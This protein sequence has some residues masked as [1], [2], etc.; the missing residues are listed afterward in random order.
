MA[1]GLEVSNV[2]F[3]QPVIAFVHASRY[4]RVEDTALARP[5]MMK[6]QEGSSRSDRQHL[7]EF[8]RGGYRRAGI[9]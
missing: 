1:S 7:V 5:R 6:S 4:L 3:A 8:D 2:F 9:L